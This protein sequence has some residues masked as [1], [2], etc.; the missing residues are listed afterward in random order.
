MKIISSLRLIFLSLG[1]LAAGLVHAQPFPGKLFSTS[2]LF[3]LL[4]S[5][6]W[7]HV[8]KPN[9]LPR[10]TTSKWL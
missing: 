4:V 2:S 7:L 1:L 8:I 6:T 9:S 10:N 5:L 3:R